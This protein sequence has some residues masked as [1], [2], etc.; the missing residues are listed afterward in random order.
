M[1]K[2]ATKTNG[3][4]MEVD[5]INLFGFTLRDSISKWGKN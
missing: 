1:F 4:I 3:E 5:V 2:K